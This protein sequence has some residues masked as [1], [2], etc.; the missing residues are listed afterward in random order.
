MCVDGRMIVKKV[1]KWERNLENITIDFHDEVDTG[2]VKKQK[3]NKK[4]TAD[5]KAIFGRLRIRQ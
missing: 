2:Q 5:V 4:Q 3:K 1:K